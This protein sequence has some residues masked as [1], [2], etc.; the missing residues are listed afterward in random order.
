MMQTLVY[1]A[2]LRKNGTVIGEAPGIAGY[3]GF[4]TG[5]K[6]DTF[7]VSYNVRMLRTNMSDIK[8]NIDRE[9]YEGYV[10]MAQLIQRALLDS[11]NY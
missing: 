8:L 10:P 11:Q 3:L 4:Y 1:K 6:Y 7:T 5:I 2:Y 9:F